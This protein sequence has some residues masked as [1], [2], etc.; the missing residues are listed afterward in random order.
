MRINTTLLAKVSVLS[1][2]CGLGSLVP[3]PSPVG[4]IALDSFPGFFAALSFGRWMGALVCFIGHVITS[5]VHGFPLGLLHSAIAVGMG[6]DGFVIGLLRKRAGVYPAC[7]AGVLVNVGLFPL[8]TPVMGFWGALLLTPY[9]AVA[10]SVNMALA[11]VV[12][13]ALKGAGLVKEDGS[14]R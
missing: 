5:L 10:S 2:L 3:F 11:F 4:T 13:R 12:Y 14:K 8:A 7:I 9:L 1:A 6:L